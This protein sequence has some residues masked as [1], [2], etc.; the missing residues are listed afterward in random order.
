MPDDSRLL[1]PKAVG[2]W[3][4]VLSFYAGPGGS[5]GY[6]GVGGRSVVGAR[7]RAV[8][9][10]AVQLTPAYRS[11]LLLP[12]LQ[13]SFGLGRP[14]HSSQRH[15]PPS[16]AAARFSLCDDNNSTVGMLLRLY[17]ASELAG[18]LAQAI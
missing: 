16:A 12:S 15:Q 9:A 11:P 5:L 7:F 2:C 1:L 6:G 10:T 18:L 14:S 3:P 13:L 4:S 8:V 17:I